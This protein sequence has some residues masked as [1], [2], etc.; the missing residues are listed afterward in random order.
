MRSYN[1]F[2]KISKLDLNN[3]LRELG[4]TL[5]KQ[6]IEVKIMKLIIFLR[7]LIFVGKINKNKFLLIK[8]KILFMKK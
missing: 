5:Q 2:N 6:D 8:R 7:Q 1:G 4:V 3:L